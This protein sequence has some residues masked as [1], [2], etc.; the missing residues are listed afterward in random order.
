MISSRRGTVTLAAALALST[1]FMPAAAEQIPALCSKE[2]NQAEM[3]RCA[4]MLLKKAN[5]EM[6]KTLKELL[7]E[8]DKENHKYVTEAQDA[9]KAWATRNASRASAAV[10]I[11]AA[12][13][14]RRCI[15]NVTSASRARG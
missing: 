7:D 8:T 13:S 11:A 15:C 3:T 9:W 14:D 5:A 10:P 6:A 2:R 1:F 12:P 4:D